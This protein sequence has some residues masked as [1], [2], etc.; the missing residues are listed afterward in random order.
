[1]H[2]LERM[3]RG[4]TGAG[5]WFQSKVTM[6]MLTIR[7]SEDLTSGYLIELVFVHWALC[8]VRHWFHTIARERTR[9]VTD[10]R[11]HHSWCHRDCHGHC[12]NL[13]DCLFSLPNTHITSI[14]VHVYIYMIYQHLHAFLALASPDCA[15]PQQGGRCNPTKMTKS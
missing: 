9:I 6:V 5:S 1:M 8:I 2:T 14:S 10:G 3:S 4:G 11:S 7:T 13:N 15:C 12:S